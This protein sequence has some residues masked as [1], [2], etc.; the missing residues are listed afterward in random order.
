MVLL[1]LIYVNILTHIQVDTLQAA[2]PR[3]DNRESFTTRAPIAMNGE[4]SSE[5]WELKL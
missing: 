3:S 5:L 2:E 1:S 4:T